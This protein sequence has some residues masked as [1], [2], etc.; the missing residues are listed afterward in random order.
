MSDVDA[1]LACTNWRLA[2]I[3]VRADRIEEV[4]ENIAENVASQFE[5]KAFPKPLPS[6]NFPQLLSLVTLPCH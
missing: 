2:N 4:A 3:E 5:K 6:K 1:K